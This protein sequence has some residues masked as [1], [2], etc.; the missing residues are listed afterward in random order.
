MN[1]A[2]VVLRGVHRAFGTRQVLCGVDLDIDAGEFLAVVGRSGTGKSTLLR[3]LAQLDRPDAGRIEAGGRCAMAFQAPH[4]LPWLTVERNV[5]LGLPKNGRA[6]AVAGALADVDLAEWA[7]AWPLTLSGGQ[8]Q[9]ASLARALVR[10]PELMLLDEP[11]GALDALT[12]LDMQSLVARLAA[13]SG[14]T[15]VMVTHDVGEALR[16]ADRVVVLDEGRIAMQV[17]VPGR[18]PRPIGF[19]GEAELSRILLERLGVPTGP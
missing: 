18:R 17:P 14:W 19:P 6:A 4:L 3:L 2:R 16:L 9:R 11:F 13:E 15:V 12:R 7:R 8:A 10:R 1:P 5:G